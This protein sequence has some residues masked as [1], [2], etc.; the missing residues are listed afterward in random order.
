V[1]VGGNPD[2]EVTLAPNCDSACSNFTLSAICMVV[3]LLSAINKGLVGM[4]RE[5]ND[6]SAIA[7][8]RHMKEKRVTCHDVC[9][10]RTNNDFFKMRASIKNFDV[11]SNHLTTTYLNTYGHLPHL[12]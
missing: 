10:L 5:T 3:I 7:D 9:C 1:C 8:S 4:K 11:T 6:D 12:I 2:C